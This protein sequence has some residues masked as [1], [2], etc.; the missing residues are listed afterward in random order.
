MQN[1][2]KILQWTAYGF[3]PRV[4]L[5]PEGL[6]HRLKTSVCK[7]LG[8][9]PTAPNQILTGGGQA[10]TVVTFQPEGYGFESSHPRSASLFGSLLLAAVLFLKKMHTMDTLIKTL[11]CKDGMNFNVLM[12]SS[13]IWSD[14]LFGAVC[15]FKSPNAS[16][17]RRRLFSVQRGNLSKDS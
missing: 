10:V 15:C 17:C 2:T 3:D 6:R 14:W 8:W 9:I 5:W 7:V 11:R 4:T 16:Q 1:R 13:L 12:G